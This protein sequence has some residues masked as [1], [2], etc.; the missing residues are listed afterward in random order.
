MQE[1]FQTS[2][3]LAQY[4]IAFLGVATIGAII[5]TC[6]VSPSVDFPLRFS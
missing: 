5:T 3:F 6:N 4:A 1:D 2:D